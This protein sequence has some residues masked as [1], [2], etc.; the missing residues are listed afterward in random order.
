MATAT[1]WQKGETLD[2]LATKDQ[3]AGDIVTLGGAAVGVIAEDVQAGQLG[4]IHVEGV[5]RMPKIAAQLALGS[6][7]YYS[8]ADEAVTG[9]ST[10][11]V[12]AGYTVEAAAAADSTVLV[13]LNG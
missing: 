6:Q 11:N 9:S 4:H 7:V 8:A 3:K 12:P 2:Y 1:Y 10:G 5:Y 13:K